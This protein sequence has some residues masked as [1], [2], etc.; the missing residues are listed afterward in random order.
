VIGSGAIEDAEMDEPVFE[1]ATRFSRKRV[2]DHEDNIT[3][4][5][6]RGQH[7]AVNP[8]RLLKLDGSPVELAE[9]VTGCGANPVPAGSEGRG[10]QHGRDMK[11]RASST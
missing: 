9:F 6:W 2:G 8:D 7:G 10:P 11:D 3:R 5:T 4:S 1:L